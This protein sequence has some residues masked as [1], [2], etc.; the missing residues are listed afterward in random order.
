M[1]ADR[2]PGHGLVAEGRVWIPGQPVRG[3]AG[4]AVCGCGVESP[5]LPNTS[6]RKRWHREHKDAIRAGAS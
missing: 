1:K 4:R 5:E 2:L 6:A 3:G